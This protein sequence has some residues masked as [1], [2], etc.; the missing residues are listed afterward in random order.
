MREQG[1]ARTLSDVGQH[2]GCCQSQSGVNHRM[3]LAPTVVIVALAQL[4][5]GSG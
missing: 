1:T 2:N 5:L 3:S 4:H